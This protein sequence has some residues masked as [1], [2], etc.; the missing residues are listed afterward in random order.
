MFKWPK[1][2]LLLVVSLLLGTGM[3]RAQSVFDQF[4]VSPA[5]LG[6]EPGITEFWGA[7]LTW[8]YPVQILDQ[9]KVYVQGPDYTTYRGGNGLNVSVDGNKL[10]IDVVNGPITNNSAW[11][12]WTLLGVENGGISVNGQVLETGNEGVSS[13]ITWAPGGIR[14]PDPTSV[15]AKGMNP[16]VGTLDKITLSWNGFWVGYSDICDSW[17]NT[18]SRIKIYEVNK[19]DLDYTN[20]RA[21]SVTLSQEG[22]FNSAGTRWYNT[23]IVTP[24]ETFS[25]PDYK[26]VLVIPSNTLGFKDKDTETTV[27]DYSEAIEIVYTVAGANA[28]IVIPGQYQHIDYRQFKGL[29]IQ[30]GNYSVANASQIGLYAGWFDTDNPIG[31]ATP[32]ATGV[33]QGSDGNILI[34]FPAASELTSGNYTIN[35]PNG[36]ITG[37][38]V[39]VTDLGNPAGQIQFVIEGNNPTIESLSLGTAPVNNATVETLESVKVWW[40]NHNKLFNPNSKADPESGEADNTPITGTMS[41]NGGEAQNVNFYITRSL[42]ATAEDEDTGAA[43]GVDYEYSLTYTPATPITVAGKY[44]FTIPANSVNVY[45]NNFAS[46]ANNQVVLNYTVEGEEEAPEASANK[47]YVAQGPNMDEIAAA[48]PATDPVLELQDNGTYKGTFEIEGMNAAFRFYSYV[49]GVYTYYSPESG[50]YAGNAWTSF[51][52]GTVTTNVLFE[53]TLAKNSGSW[54][55]NGYPE[56]SVGGIVT[57]VVNLGSTRDEE[58]DKVI[59]D[60]VTTL[61]FEP[62][63]SGTP[64]LPEELLVV[65]DT[66]EAGSFMPSS[67]TVGTFKLGEDGTYE[68]DFT[69]VSRPYFKF[70]AEENGT[71]IYYA[72]TGGFNYI[73]LDFDLEDTYSY[74]TITS[75]S[76]LGTGGWIA[77][78]NTTIHA[79]VDLAKNTITLSKAE[80]QEGPGEDYPAAVY[81]AWGTDHNNVSVSLFDQQMK[82]GEKGIYTASFEYNTS[83]TKK[84]FRLYSD[85]NVVPNYISVRNGGYDFGM[86][87]RISFAD[88]LSVDYSNLFATTD[89]SNAGSWTIQNFPEGVTEG[90]IELTLNLVNKTLNVTLVP[91]EVKEPETVYLAFA[92]NGQNIS[93]DML[94]PAA[95]LKMD[96]QQDGSYLFEYELSNETKEYFGFLMYTVDG[97]NYMSIGEQGGATWGKGSNIELPKPGENMEETFTN[98]KQYPVGAAYGGDQA[99]FTFVNNNSFVSGNATLKLSADLQTLEVLVTSDKT[100]EPGIQL[101]NLIAN[102]ANGST[103]QWFNGIAMRWGTSR[104][105]LLNDR[106]F[107]VTRNGVDITKDPK[108]DF[109]M[110]TIEYDPDENTSL[111]DVQL[112]IEATGIYPMTEEGTY[113]FTVYPGAVNINVDGKQVANPQVELIYYIGKQGPAAQL[114]EPTVNPANNSK[115]DKL[116]NVTLSWNGYEVHQ[117]GDG[118]GGMLKDI[119]YTVNGGSPKVIDVEYQGNESVAF[120]DYYP[121]LVLPINAKESGKYVITIPAGALYVANENA[122][123]LENKEVVLTY[124]VT[125]TETPAPVYMTG[126]SVDPR[127]GSRLANMGDVYITW[128]NY[129]LDITP[130]PNKDYVNLPLDKVTATLNGE[131]VNLNNMFGVIFRAINT[132]G[133]DEGTGGTSTFHVAE[134]QFYPGNLSF[135]WSGTLNLKFEEGLVKSTTGAISPAFDLTYYLGGQE[136]VSPAIFTPEEGSKFLPGEAVVYAEWEGY[137]VTAINGG[138]TVNTIDEEG[139]VSGSTSISNSQLSIEGGKLRIDLTSLPVGSYQMWLQ[140]GAVNLGDNAVNA[141]APYAFT[142]AVPEPEGP[143]ATDIEPTINIAEG[144]ITISWDGNDIELTDDFNLTIVDNT[145]GEEV[146]IWDGVVYV[147]ENGNL[148]IDLEELELGDG[149][150]TLTLAEGSVNIDEDGTI[151]YNNEVTY[152]FKTSGIDFFTADNEVRYFTIEGVEVKNPAPGQILIRVQNG[153]ATKV[154][155]K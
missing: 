101:P 105:T 2:W 129:T 49:D 47:L 27:D 118:E 98:L 76:A 74:N 59:M 52:N 53:T 61:S 18:Q 38:S 1:V 55:I 111:E 34:A 45:I 116:E 83:D 138:V 10:L 14:I 145:T 56:G 130:E 134:I 69:I 140:Q 148:V 97:S 112:Q 58:N 85:E 78:P 65:T 120:E 87:E 141:D 119:T 19:N 106:G 90:T 136:V 57:A 23:L 68:G 25:N 37:F 39:P 60:A 16:Q 77:Q 107:K 153:E 142:I 30:G 73:N 4:T 29:Q 82:N 43:D 31:D 46:P 122:G 24:A 11:P 36:S 17:N 86:D 32:I 152:D 125:V 44:T 117:I 137:N 127:D 103:V 151:T 7:T 20:G 64:D 126:G 89:G 42:I 72:A 50:G 128:G 26:Y 81:I 12:A 147:D 132:Q 94:N 13:Q 108:F 115:L 109:V 154:L 3:T 143:E 67:G 149:D 102:P 62:T 91:A 33:S 79:V 28:A 88:G 75:G 80:G 48:N 63:I 93:K 40:G 146:N 104:L 133:S 155:V 113:V 121:T 96:M 95:D 124:D 35:V 5:N 84:T 139:D 71:G 92:P 54:R 123:S 99:S 8:N 144:K 6:V 114:P 100:E 131:K 150:Y 22:A 51:A 41:V 110:Q 9:S 66:Q 21:I 15:P 70:Y 135:Y